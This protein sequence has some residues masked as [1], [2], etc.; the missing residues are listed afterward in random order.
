VP[1]RRPAKKYSV[2]FGSRAS[3]RAYR[4]T[5]CPSWL[6]RASNRPR[7]IWTWVLVYS[8]YFYALLHLTSPRCVAARASPAWPR[9]AMRG[10]RTHLS[11]RL[12]LP[13]ITPRTTIVAATHS[14]IFRA[15]V[16]R[17][18]R[19]STPSQSPPP[20]HTRH[21]TKP[22]PCS[23]DRASVHLQQILPYR[24]TRK[25]FQGSVAEVACRKR[26]QIDSVAPNK[27]VRLSASR[28]EHGGYAKARFGAT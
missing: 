23:S 5:A 18:T 19:P 10:K 27:P 3:F 12:R 4:F 15:F 16:A 1:H 26:V 24:E 9:G 13:Q 28:H 17:L 25:S 8:R 7:M 20:S 14:A 6:A 22:F 11:F 2:N 21:S